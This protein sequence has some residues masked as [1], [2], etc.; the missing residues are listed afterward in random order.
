MTNKNNTFL[1]LIET[2]LLYYLLLNLG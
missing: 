1:H 2:A